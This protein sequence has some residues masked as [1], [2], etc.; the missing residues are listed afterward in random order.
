MELSQQKVGELY[1]LAFFLHMYFH[2][3]RLNVFSLI[4]LME[5]SSNTGRDITVLV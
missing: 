4:F 3:E 1:L 5:K 2:M